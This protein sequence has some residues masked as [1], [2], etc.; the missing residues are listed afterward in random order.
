MI[1]S[2]LL[3]VLILLSRIAFNK[4]AADVIWIVLFWIGLHVVNITGPICIYLGFQQNRNSYQKCCDVCDRKFRNVCNSLAERRM[5][6]LPKANIKMHGMIPSTVK[7]H[8][9]GWEEF[10]KV[11]ITNKIIIILIILAHININ[12]ELSVYFIIPIGIYLL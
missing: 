12:T 2:N 6:K 11:C 9:I 1:I 7:I 5:N 8:Y 3:L 10:G 4:N